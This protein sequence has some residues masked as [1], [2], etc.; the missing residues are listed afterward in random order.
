VITMIRVITTRVAPPWIPEISIMDLTVIGGSLVCDRVT[1]WVKP[2]LV[3]GLDAIDEG[4]EAAA[5]DKGKGGGVI[6][7]S[8]T[9]RAV[10]LEGERVNI[11]VDT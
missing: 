7:K 6:G 2:M 11:I 3:N 8:L 4:N 9:S 1:I 10:T 5:E